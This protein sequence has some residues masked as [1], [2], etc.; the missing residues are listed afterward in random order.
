[1]RPTILPLVVMFV[2]IVACSRPLDAP[3]PTAGLPAIVL[4]TPTLR[5]A[6]LPSQRTPAPTF[7]PAPTPTL[8]VHIVE[9]GDTLIDIANRYQTTLDD[10]Q[11]ANGVLNPETLQIGQ[12]LIIPATTGSQRL[13]PGQ[14]GLLLP[15]PVPLPVSIQGTALYQSP[16]GS[17]WVLGEIWNSGETALENTQVEV[18]LLDESGLEVASDTA[19]TLLDVIAR[20]NTAPFGVLFTALPAEVASFEVATIRAEVSQE[21]GGRY[22]SIAI[23]DQQDALDGLQ[24]NVS[25][26]LANQSSQAAAEVVVIITTYD[27]EGRVTGY[28]QE[29]VG[30]GTLAAGGIATFSISIAPNGIRNSAPDHYTLSAQG[31]VKP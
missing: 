4:S 5:S 13:L 10:L 18:I 24:F 26:S 1:M 15:T 3:T 12:S 20:G 31:R 11:A 30:D 23:A 19:F 16:A 22:V 14:S 7:T 29:A 25:G 21:P 6:R 8:V 17:I 9:P 28:R 27:V 2:L